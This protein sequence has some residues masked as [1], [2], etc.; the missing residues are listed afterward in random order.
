MGH[1]SEI[2]PAHKAMARELGYALTLK[3]TYG[4]HS[5][6]QLAA[7]ELSEVDRASLSFAALQSLTPDLIEMT[8]AHVLGAAGCPLPPFL[9]GMDEARLWAA[10]A[11]T[12]ERK[13]VALAA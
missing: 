4:W 9:G 11:T 8:A 10:C 13:A 6:T 7:A 1:G 2:A 3:R 5:F 12:K